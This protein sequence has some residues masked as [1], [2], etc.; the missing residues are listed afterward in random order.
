MCVYMI[1]VELNQVYIKKDNKYMYLTSLR[2]F[3][4]TKDCI[5]KYFKSVATG[6]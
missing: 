5:I 3:K 1:D 4:Q 6:E 2:N